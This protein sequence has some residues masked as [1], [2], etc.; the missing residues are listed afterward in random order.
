MSRSSW[1]LKSLSSVQAS[2]H[3][4]DVHHL[5]HVISVGLE[6]ELILSQMAQKPV[7]RGEVGA[8]ALRVRSDVRGHGQ[9]RL[10]KA[11]GCGIASAFLSLA[12]AA[13]HWRGQLIIGEG[14]GFCGCE[15]PLDRGGL[16][17]V[18]RGGIAGTSDGR[19]LLWDWRAP[20]LVFY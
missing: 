10:C 14:S 15:H 6:L 5:E 20:S 8:R 19:W 1:P 17:G 3:P 18:R 9:V 4:H 12:R 2:R 7:L 13:Y 11:L 16:P